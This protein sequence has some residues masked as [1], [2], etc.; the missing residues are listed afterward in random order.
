[1][2]RLDLSM[3][4]SA[5]T[6]GKKLRDF[7]GRAVMLPGGSFPA[8]IQTT[9]ARFFAPG[10]AAMFDGLLHKSKYLGL[11]LGDGTGARANVGYLHEAPTGSGT[12]LAKAYFALRREFGLK[13]D[14]RGLYVDE[15]GAHWLDPGGM[16]HQSQANLTVSSL[17]VAMDGEVQDNHQESAKWFAS[18]AL[19]VNSDT[20]PAVFGIMARTM[21]LRASVAEGDLRFASLEGK[22]DANASLPMFLIG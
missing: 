10:Q 12:P 15:I 21:A 6:V 5:D 14:F 11:H 9:V 2:S 3:S 19:T 17:A 20:R 16:G 13:K 18:V 8:G 1:M 4:W 22:V 7:L